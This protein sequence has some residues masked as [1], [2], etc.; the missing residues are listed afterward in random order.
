MDRSRALARLLQELT[1]LGATRRELARTLDLGL[2]PSALATA[3]TL[4][5]RGPLRI[6]TLAAELHTDL[7]VV[8]RTVAELGEAGLVERQPDPEDRRAC[9]VSLS[10]AGVAAVDRAAEQVREGLGPS[11]AD[12]DDAQ[13]E[14]VADGL[15]RLR[16]DLLRTPAA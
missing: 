12:W 10:P 8:S 14:G 15:A 4:Q 2:H 7:S 11:L 6:S 16:T 5:A 1:A 9:L 13:L 3:W